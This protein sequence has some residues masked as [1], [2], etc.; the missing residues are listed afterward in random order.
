[1]RI[2]REEYKKYMEVEKQSGEYDE[3][4]PNDALRFELPLHTIEMIKKNKYHLEIAFHTG[5]GNPIKAVEID[6]W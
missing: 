2:T 1:M 6:Y 5:Y 4:V 3:F